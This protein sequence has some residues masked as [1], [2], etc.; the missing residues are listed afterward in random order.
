VAS[1][2]RQGDNGSLPD[3]PA[4][5]SDTRYIAFSSDAR[6]LVPNDTNDCADVF[7]RDRLTFPDVPLDHWAFYDVGACNMA[8][9]VRGYPDGLYHPNVK[10]T[11]DQM[12]V[13]I[14]RALA[15][16][17]EYVPTGPAQATFPDVPADH[18]AFDEVEYAVA[19]N[20]V[21]GYEDGNYHPDWELTRAQMAV[22][23]A[24]SVV[25]P[26]GEAGLAGYDPPD[27]PSFPD[28]PSGYWS[29]KHIEYC[30]ERGIV[31][32]YPDG[33]YKPTQYVTR[34][35]MAVYLQRAFRL[36]M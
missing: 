14:S 17:E 27:V 15:G 11:R 1:D 29:Y 12:A 28:V 2:G 24:R 32:G 6:N 16:G 35:Q 3:M 23:I 5:S 20:V 10:I 33:T 25:T 36:P 7:V 13:Y 9:I 34:D 8:G 21:Q 4:M 31:A 22:F 30:K 19:N 18:W 26:T